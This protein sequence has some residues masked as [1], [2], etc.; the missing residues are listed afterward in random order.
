M[1]KPWQRARLRCV[2]FGGGIGDELMCSAVFREIKRRNPAC[3]L[4]FHARVPVLAR[5]NP[6]ID[7]IV[8]FDGDAIPRDAVWLTYGPSIPPLRSLPEMSAEC[9]G[10]RLGDLRPEAPREEPYVGSRKEWTAAPVAGSPKRAAYSE[11]LIAR[12]NTI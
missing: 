1:R 10:L 12:H 11:D 8:P 5:G 2:S 3:H 6:H 4:T 7:E 9:V